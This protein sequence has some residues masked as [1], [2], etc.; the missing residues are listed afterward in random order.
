MVPAVVAAAAG[1]V[2]LG[3]EAIGP[4]SLQAPATAA[5]IALKKR[6]APYFIATDIAEDFDARQGKLRSDALTFTKPEPVRPAARPDDA[7]VLVFHRGKRFPRAIAWFGFRSFWGHLW[8]LAASMIATEDI[9]ARDWMHATD[10]DELTAR[11]ARL[12]G[13]TGSQGSLTDRLE[14]DLWL[15]Y[16]ADTGDCSELSQAVAD[17]L[18]RE[19]VVPDPDDGEAE[20]LAPRGALLLFG[21]DTAY[22]VATELEIHNRVCAPFN[23]VLRERVDGRL[24]VLLGIPGNHDWYDGLDGFARMFRAPRGRI[25]RDSLVTG[26]ASVDR[27]GQLGHF[28]EWVEAFRVGT[29]VT[30]RPALPLH[31][32]VPIQNASYYALRLAPRLELWGVDRQL[33]EVD[34]A[35]RSHFA[36][37]RASDAPPGLLLVIAD[38]VRTMLQPNPVGVATLDALGL[39]LE[40]DAPLVL[41]GDT[42]HYCRQSFGGATHVIAGGGGAFLHPAPMWRHGC[43]PSPEA[44]FPGPRASFGLALQVPWQLAW[45]RAGYMV[46]AGIAALYL[47]LVLLERRG[48]SVTNGCIVVGLVAAFFATLIGGLGRPRKLAIA[49][50]ATVY[51]AWVG[52]LPLVMHHAI[53]AFF[54]EN[55][56]A[57][58]DALIACAVAVIPAT[59]GMGTFLMVLTLLGLELNQGFSALAHPGYKHFVRLRVKRDGSVVDGWVFGRVDPLDPASHTV[60]VDQ[61][62][63]ANPGHVR[64]DGGDESSR[65]HPEEA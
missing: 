18:F 14:S 39:D 11:L 40:A 3:P 2:G 17:M 43:D 37:E 20:I 34:F 58:A 41:A 51:G 6:D 12:L 55:H 42:H 23:R 22:P 27:T 45:G 57:G 56:A 9:D 32:Y 7:P 52:I 28:F 36:A 29:R 35:Q 19:Y 30:K 61:F 31:G 15:D 13:A 26:D 65:S 25:A 1:P 62:R 16:V 46:H 44:E 63:W 24:R 60:L 21:G 59:L 64:Q 48:G 10:P 53:H 54:G 38:P 49:A 5:K 8:H 4:G 33:S 50:L 47:P